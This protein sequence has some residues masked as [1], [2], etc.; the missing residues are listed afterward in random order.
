MKNPSYLRSG[1]IARA[2]GISQDTLR[3][4]ERKGIIRKPGRSPNNYRE[5]SP[6]VVARVRI[7]RRAV[8]LGFTLDE[9]SE[10]FRMRDSGG[11]PCR[12]VRNLARSKL[13]RVEAA[14]R[15]LHSLRRSLR[16]VL[17]D[18]DAAI[19]RARGRRANLLENL[20]KQRG[21]LGSVSYHTTMPLRP[22]SKRGTSE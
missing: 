13:S 6:D 11:A 19:G 5:Y 2:T 1:A 7:A 10:I 9:L 20:G 14:I 4:Y 3:H 18:W 8:A 12:Q 22:V 15:E 21:R 17:S 16:L